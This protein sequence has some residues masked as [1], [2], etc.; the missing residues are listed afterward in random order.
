MHVVIREG[1]REVRRTTTIG[2]DILTLLPDA[3]AA[4]QPPIA[5]TPQ[6]IVRLPTRR[7][8]DREVMAEI[9]AHGARGNVRAQHVK[10]CKCNVC[11]WAR[12]AY[13]ADPVNVYATG[14]MVREV[15]RSARSIPLDG[16]MAGE[17]LK[18]WPA[19]HKP[20]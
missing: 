14:R 11:I 9:A 17:V 19:G 8:R 5:G 2:A 15:I 12:A 3:C 6:A 20:K 10:S 7:E 4:T 13:A 16:A 18:A 1:D